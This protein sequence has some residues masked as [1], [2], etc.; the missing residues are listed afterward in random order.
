MFKKSQQVSADKIRISCN[1]NL[2]HSAPIFTFGELS[3]DGTAA[4]KSF[5]FAFE[6]FAKRQLSSWIIFF[7]EKSLSGAFDFVI[8]AFL[9]WQWLQEQFFIH[10][11]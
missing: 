7:R 3:I 6:T 5:L 2:A 10:Q 8:F 9:Q 4:M 1:L 11:G